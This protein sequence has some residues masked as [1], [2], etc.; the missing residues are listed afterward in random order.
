[1]VTTSCEG[2][3]RGWRGRRARVHVL[4][5]GLLRLVERGIVSL[6][7][8]PAQ[9]GEHQREAGPYPVSSSVLS[10]ALAL[11]RCP[12]AGDQRVAGGGGEPER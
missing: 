4:L 12:V 6:L 3:V 10:R 9:H 1:M 7:L 2:E 11:P 5:R 8:R